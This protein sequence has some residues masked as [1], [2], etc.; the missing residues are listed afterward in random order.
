MDPQKPRKVVDNKRK[1]FLSCERF[2][3]RPPAPSNLDQESQ[4]ASTC[5]PCCTHNANAQVSATRS[6]TARQVGEGDRVGANFAST[7]P[8]SSRARIRGPKLA[9]P[10]VK[11]SAEKGA[12]RMRT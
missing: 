1:M 8:A 7:V 10:P 6:A 4:Q 2:A 5:L 12:A 3:R 11:I 9:F